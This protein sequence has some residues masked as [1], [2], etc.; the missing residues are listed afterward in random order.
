MALSMKKDPNL[1]QHNQHVA[2]IVPVKGVPFYGYHVGYQCYLKIYLLKPSY[3]LRMVELLQRG[4]VMSTLF[5]PHE[6]HIP[7]ELQ[8]L[9]DY[10][11]YG[12]NWI[13]LENRTTAPIKF[14]S[15]LPEERKANIH[16][17]PGS[18]PEQLENIFTRYTVSPNS[19]SEE[20]ERSS[21]CELEVDVICSSIINR[22]TIKERDIHKDFEEAFGLLTTKEKEIS[23]QEAKLVHSL[24]AIWEEESRRRTSKGQSPQVPPVTQ[25]DDR[26][27]HLGW[28]SE[29]DYRSRLHERVQSELFSEEDIRK[30]MDK[31]AEDDRSL[32]H[33]L[34]AW[35][36]VDAMNIDCQSL[37]VCIY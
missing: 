16:L 19:V 5:Q 6:A 17:T 34:T 26:E 32:R 35:E 28:H 30:M 33:L 10:N 1:S 25:E 37:N 12:M 23:S 14:R 15:P 3:K 36:A 29:S 27:E 11:L 2:A 9:M 31:V 21:H 18:N 4:G 13:E 24:A 22:Q 7:Y 8:F 20:Y